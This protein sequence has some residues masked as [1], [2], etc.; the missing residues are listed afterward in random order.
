M[1]RAACKSNLRQ[2]G[3]AANAHC[4]KLGYYPS[5]GWGKNWLGDPDCGFGASQP[6][7]WLYS[8]LP[9]IGMDTIHDIAGGKG[10]S[11]ISDKASGKVGVPDAL[12]SA[13]IPL[14]ICA[15]RRKAIAYPLTAVAMNGKTPNPALGGKT[16]YAVNGGSIPFGDPRLVSTP[17]YAP[18]Y[19]GTDPGP[20]INC[21]TAFPKCTW[22]YPDQS[23]FNGVSG[24]RSQVTPGQI[25]DG[26]S[27]VFL[28]GEKYVNTTCYTNGAD[29]GDSN[30]IFA[31][32]DYSNARWVF[33]SSGPSV[34]ITNIAAPMKDNNKD[35]GLNTPTAYWFGSCHSQGTHFL[36]CDG[37]VKMLPYNI[38]F[39]TYQSLSVRND[40]T[41]DEKF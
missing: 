28:A 15:A 3:E 5:N 8:L 6:G 37:S 29:Y 18:S 1:R 22:S 36:F 30:S 17:S 4:T 35:G 12:Q 13:T 34:P 33:F 41:A 14:F 21:Y 40:G 25:Q 16:D 32:N 39:P 2:I 9:F 31:G 7:G 26:L 11:I 38:D 27:N 24:A 20:P 19:P 23:A 10:T